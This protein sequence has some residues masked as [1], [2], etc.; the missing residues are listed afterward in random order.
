[1]YDY[2]NL[3][4]NTGVC[5]ANTNEHRNQPDPFSIQMERA[6]TTTTT[7]KTKWNFFVAKKWERIGEE[8]E[9]EEKEKKTRMRK[10]KKDYIDDHHHH[11]HHRSINI[12]SRQW[13]TIAILLN[14]IVYREGDVRKENGNKYVGFYRCFSASMIKWKKQRRKNG[15][16]KK[17]AERKRNTEITSSRLWPDTWCPRTSHTISKYIHLWLKPLKLCGDVGNDISIPLPF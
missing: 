5:N 13:I 17:R 9:E 10:R 6:T 1:M 11:H 12:Y 3:Y 8:E 2:S 14:V 15:E 16:K 4:Q 7:T